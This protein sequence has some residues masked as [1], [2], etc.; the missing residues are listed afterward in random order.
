MK[1]LTAS[2]ARDLARVVTH[3]RFSDLGR[4]YRGW[5]V[6]FRGGPVAPTILRATLRA[7]LRAAVRWIEENP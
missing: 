1:H 4:C 6:G 5:A 3:R 7:A 2:E